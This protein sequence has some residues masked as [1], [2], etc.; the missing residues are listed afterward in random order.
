MGQYPDADLLGGGWLPGRQPQQHDR[1]YLTWLHL[2]LNRF[3]PA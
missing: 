1:D 3:G 2:P